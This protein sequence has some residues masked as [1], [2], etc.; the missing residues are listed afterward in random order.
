MGLHYT[1]LLGIA[2]MLSI[3]LLISTDRR[4]IN[5]KGVVFGISA[6]VLFAI[7]ILKT[8]VGRVFFE[9]VNGVIGA[10]MHFQQEGGRFVFNTLAI[11]PEQNG[12]IG[13]FF[14]FQVLTTIIFFSS[15]MSVCYYFGI[16]QRC[17]GL[18]AK[19]L[20]KLM[21]VSGA[22]SLTASANIFIG[23][24]EAPL[25]VR[26]YVK[27][28]TQSELLCIMAAGMATVAGSI[29]GAY[30]GML[31]DFFPDI[32][33]HLLACTVM[34]APGAIVIAKIMIPETQVPVTLGRV[35][36]ESADQ[37][38]NVLEA[39]VNGAEVGL[40]LALNVGTMLIAF[41]ALLAMA[42]ALLGW[43]TNLL[44]LGTVTFQNIFGVLFAPLAW[45]MGV[46][47]NECL[48]VGQLIGEKTAINELVAY[49]HLSDIL[50]QNEQAL[51]ERSILIC[52]YALCGFANILSIGI[53]I[54]G[55]GALAPER[56]SDIAKL[57][58]RALIAGSL[59]TFMTTSIASFLTS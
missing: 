28:M 40:K 58:I 22:E 47:W 13:F 55:I 59:A 20:R 30:V 56:K 23:Q 49:M 10:L 5:W 41:M 57:G 46:P 44:G 11:P 37:P 4:A 15:L 2:T 50:R 45:V 25:L 36:L 31:R 48:L 32:G 6:Q 12:S 18:F 52:S 51:S 26:P 3:A 42:N 7:L 19:G 34:S 16:M 29:L 17:V 39:I 14:A 8:V 21:G 53:Q 24:T 1:S 33:G 27:D 43:S 35:P 9:W 54:G 38:K